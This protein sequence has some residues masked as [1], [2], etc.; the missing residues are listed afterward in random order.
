MKSF[1]GDGTIKMLDHEMNQIW[2]DVTND[3]N[4]KR[5][6]KTIHSYKFY[7]PSLHEKI[8]TGNMLEID[9][10]FLFVEEKQQNYCIAIG[11]EWT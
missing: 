4:V 8:T 1:D 3:G 9:G 10:V 11:E 5:L 2:K 7:A 6:I